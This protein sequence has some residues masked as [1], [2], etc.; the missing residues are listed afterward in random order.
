M[1]ELTGVL[2]AGTEGRELR[3]LRGGVVGYGTVVGGVGAPRAAGTELVGGRPQQAVGGGGGRGG[4]GGGG[5]V[6]AV[7]VVGG[8]GERRLGVQA[9]VGVGVLVVRLRVCCV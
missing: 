3:V 7:G 5:R 4:G 8:R 9:L 6:A 1:A 2:V